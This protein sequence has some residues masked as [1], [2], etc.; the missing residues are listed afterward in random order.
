MTYLFTSNFNDI[1]I[2]IASRAIGEIGARLISKNI[3]IRQIL[4]SNL[5]I[6]NPNSFKFLIIYSPNCKYSIF[7]LR[8]KFIKI[9]L[10]RKSI[11]ILSL[12]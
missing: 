5:N 2:F 8:F 12:A 3:F 1:L 9:I 4:L 11:F 10:S 7:Y 6:S